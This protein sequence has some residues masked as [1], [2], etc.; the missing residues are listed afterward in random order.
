MEAFQV[1]G[2][3]DSSE[4]PFEAD[5]AT[6][7]TGCVFDSFHFKKLLIK[8]LNYIINAGVFMDYCN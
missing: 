1:V 7:E 5:L 3:F 8:L 6:R 2:C 4:L